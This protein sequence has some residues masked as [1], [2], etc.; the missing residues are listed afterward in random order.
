VKFFATAESQDGLAWNDPPN[1][2]IGTY[3]AIV[4][5]DVEVVLGD[6]CET[7]TGWTVGFPGDSAT[8]GVWTRVD[9]NGTLS[10]PEDDHSPSGTRCWVT[11]Q[12]TPGGSVDEA[13]VDGGVTT[14]VTPALP[15]QGLRDPK[16]NY[17]RWF[18]NNRGTGTPDDSLFVL[19]SNDD[20]HWVTVER[21]GPS[22]PQAGGGWFF[23]EFRVADYVAPSNKVRVRFVASDT[24]TPSIV[25][26][27]VDDLQVI[28]TT[29]LGAT[30]GGARHTR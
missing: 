14:L 22:S 12:G 8:A 15:L 5:Q 21:V 28:D 27:A 3:S 11:G 19:V 9:P 30:D 20:V 29:C 26:A 6:G 4:A 2:P 17:W 24:G 18:S 23:S 1:A 10:Q 7:D 25:E 13:D 16:I